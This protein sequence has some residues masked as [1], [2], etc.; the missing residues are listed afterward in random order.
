MLQGTQQYENGSAGQYLAAQR[1]LSDAFETAVSG[2]FLSKFNFC[3]KKKNHG[4]RFHKSKTCGCTAF[5]QM[6]FFDASGKRCFRGIS[7][8][9]RAAPKAWQERLSVSTGE[10]QRSNDAAAV[11]HGREAR[12]EPRNVPE[13][14]ALRKMVFSFVPCLCPCDSGAGFR[15]QTQR[16]GV[17]DRPAPGIASV[18]RRHPGGFT[19]RGVIVVFSQPGLRGLGGPRLP[20]GVRAWLHPRTR[21]TQPAVPTLL[22]VSEHLA[23]L[24][25]LFCFKK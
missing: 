20:P 2:S 1:P 8:R 5:I 15:E 7:Y 25:G 16:C 21:Q 23:S 18:S 19:D 10:Q 12:G 17:P 3:L 13:Q 24:Q 22:S 11:S 6:F 9:P 4:V 14:I